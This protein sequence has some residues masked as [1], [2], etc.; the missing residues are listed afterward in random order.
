[1]SVTLSDQT[2]IDPDDELLVAYLDGELSAREESELM[3][4]LLDDE[5]LNERL[6][7]LQEGWDWLDKLPDA[8]PN[9]KLVESTLELVVADV[10][11]QAPAKQ[12]SKGRYRMPLLTV[13]ACLF[14]AAGA[15]FYVK[16]QRDRQYRQQLEDLVVAENLDAYLYGKDLKL[17]RSLASDTAWANMVE[18]ASEVGVFGAVQPSRIANTPVQERQASLESL[19]HANRSVLYS[20]WERFSRLKP[21]QIAELRKTASAV[22]L[23]ADADMLLE[24]M[25]AYA[26]WREQLPPQLRD[27]IESDDGPTRREA[28]DKGIELVQNETA[29]RSR[30]QIDEETVERIYYVLRRILRQRLSDGDESMQKMVKFAEQISGGRDSEP[31]KVGMILLGDAMR[32]GGRGRGPRPPSFIEHSRGLDADEMEMIRL[33]LPNSAVDMLDV[34]AGGDEIVEDLVLRNWAEESVRRK[35]PVWKDDSTLLERYTELP[36]DDRETL[37]L[38]PPGRMLDEITRPRSPWGGGDKNRRRESK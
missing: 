17:M 27:E 15:A 3:N 37:D 6:Q 26:V 19:E 30:S 14:F 8:T 20:R 36:D 29:K 33:V 13:I 11:K 12:D 1:M 25:K 22:Q 2:P 5:E 21:E 4:R 23:Q 9:E 34:V 16:N 18:A 10:I 31:I 28:I 32:R 38:S 24:T 35:M 7:R